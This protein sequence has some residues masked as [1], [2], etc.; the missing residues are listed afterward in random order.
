MK[1]RWSSTYVMLRRAV[2]LKPFLNEF[3][4]Q[5]GREESDT[6]KRAKIDA[7]V[8]SRE[9][10]QAF[11]YENAP[12]LHNALP[13]LEALHNFWTHYSELDEYAVFEDGLEAAL[14]KI[15]DYYEKTSTSHAYT[16]AMLLDPETKMDHFKRHWSAD[17]QQRVLDAAE[18]TFKERYLEMYG[19]GS[20]GP[21]KTSKKG[22]TV[23][24]PRH[25]HRLLIAMLPQNLGLQNFIN[26]SMVLM[27]YRM[28]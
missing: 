27:K 21:P 6:A 3:I 11:S 14:A 24:L 7:L 1:V 28:V 26:T 17:L 2:E 15:A 18:E 22:S 13:A 16:F 8:L 12:T 20:R 5:T 4:Y 19:P 10:W 9:E 23:P 25:H